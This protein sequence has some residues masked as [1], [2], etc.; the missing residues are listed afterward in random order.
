MKN[1]IGDLPRA[2]L[3]NGL[4]PLCLSLVARRRPSPCDRAARAARRRRATAPRA[5]CACARLRRRCV[6]ARRRATYALECT[7]RAEGSQLTLRAAELDDVGARNRSHARRAAGRTVQ[8]IVQPD[9][10]TVLLSLRGGWLLLSADARA[11][12][13]HLVEQAAR[14]RRGGA[15]V[16]HALAQGADR[17]CRW[18]RCARSPASAPASSTFA[19]RRATS[20]AAAVPLRRRARSCSS[21]SGD[22]R[23]ARRHRA[24]QAPRPPSCRRRARDAERG[25]R[26]FPRGAAVAGDRRAL[27]RRRRRRRAR[28]QVEAQ[29]RAA[30]QEARAPAWPALE[31]DRARAVA[32]VD[33]RKHADLLARAPAARCRTAPRR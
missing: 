33:K 12:R 3:G 23:I 21:S 5:G 1:F 25:E 26:R 24:G 20:G 30:R 22:G 2:V 32:A 19:A 18:R 29:R 17:A 31:R 11:G 13:M 28:A 9:D 7:A 8:K 27:R 10:A 6:G 15:G 4:E 14:H 16:L